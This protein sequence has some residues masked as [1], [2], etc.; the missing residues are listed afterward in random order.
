MKSDEA[1]VITIDGPSGAGKGTIALRLAD[2]LGFRLLDS[3]AVYRAAAVFLLKRQ[4]SLTD[5]TAVIANL[6]GLSVRFESTLTATGTPGVSGVSGVFGISVWVNGSEVTNELRT[7]ATADAASTIAVI[8]A[9][10]DLLLAIQRDCRQP[11][12]LVADGRDMG[13]VV[14]PDA[15]LKVYLTASVEERASRRH[16]QLKEQG[17]TVTLESL[18][19]ELEVRDNRD[20]TRKTSPLM[21]AK[22]ALVIDSTGISADVV[23]DQVV[24]AFEERSRSSI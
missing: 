7:E 20:S 3:G 21:P 13:T 23:L 22:N 19:Q 9:V 4:V 11:P 10:R 8:P 1:P 24:S 6:S 17:L 5:E 12:G 18:L 15:R 2:R 14:F 16:K